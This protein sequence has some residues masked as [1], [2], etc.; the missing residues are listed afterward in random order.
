MLYLL[1]SSFTHLYIEELPPFYRIDQIHVK[2][3]RRK[4]LLPSPTTVCLFLFSF[5]VF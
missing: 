3:N 1:I 4:E 2:V 5:C